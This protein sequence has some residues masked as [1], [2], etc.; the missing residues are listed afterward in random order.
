MLHE[1]TDPPRG[2]LAQLARACVAIAALALLAIAAVQL[3]QVFARYVLNDSPGWTE[4]V[5]LVLLSTAMMF[6]AAAAVRSDGHFGFALLLLAAPAGVQRVLRSFSSLL[7]AVLGAL[8]AVGGA[9]LARGDW[10][11]ALP[12]TAFPQGA[13]YVPLMAGG[14]LMAL[15]ALERAWRAWRDDARDRAVAAEG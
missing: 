14:A 12:G 1:A 6:A 4:P 10:D 8:L 15:F 3:W 7:V 13:L 5:T 11:V 9:R 2:L